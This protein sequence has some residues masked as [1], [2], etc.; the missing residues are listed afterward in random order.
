M[1]KRKS[2]GVTIK[3]NNVKIRDIVNGDKNVTNV[4]GTGIAIGK[5]ARATV[6]RMAD[7]SDSAAKLT[8]WQKQMESRIDAIAKFSV[9]DKQ[10]LKDQVGKIKIEASKGNQADLS[11]LEKYINV[12]AEW[13]PDMLEVATQTLVNPLAGFGLIL[14]KVGDKAKLERAKPS[15]QL[16]LPKG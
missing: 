9:N 12:L 13:G 3:A 8:E 7:S 10:D 5:G 4:S 14:K 1:A 6:T 15:S 2:S 16:Q 11:R